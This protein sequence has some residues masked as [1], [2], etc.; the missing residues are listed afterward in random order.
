MKK[1]WNRRKRDAEL[2]KEIQHHLQ[3][4]EMERIER[5]ASQN[6]AQAGAR[7]E[8]GNVGLVKELARDAWG[9]RWLED[10][11]EDLR[12]GA[13][14]LRKSPG[15]TATAILTLALGIGVNAAI[16]SVVYAVLLRPLPYKDPARLL[17]TTLQFPK[18]DMHRSFVPHPMYF[19]WRD[20]NDVFSGIAATNVGR[21][22]TLTG[23]GIPERIRGMGVSAN[24]FSV[25]GVEL[26][27]GRSFTPEEDR[28]GGPRGAILSYELWQSR[29]AGDPK[30]L[31][32]LIMLDDKGYPIVGVLPA[33]FKFP[34]S[35]RPPE[36]FVPLAAPPDA[37]SAIWYLEVIARLKPGVT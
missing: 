23:A 17:W 33:S 2:E 11:Y 5:G 1:W 37:S 21:R 28:R 20:Q 3:M 32:R 13:R 29:Y 6:E 7:R 19:A 4:A 36:V 12:F 10:L 25:L 22:F 24:F 18:T 9:W 34:T 31:G 8:F 14:T 35:G 30:I 27:R 16:F 15:F 26:A